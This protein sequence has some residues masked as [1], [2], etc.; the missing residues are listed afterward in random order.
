MYSVKAIS[1]KTAVFNQTVKHRIALL[2]QQGVMELLLNIARGPDS[3]NKMNDTVARLPACQSWEEDDADHAW[4]K[5][6][7]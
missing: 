6:T 5:C 1:V 4:R 7:G 3:S 2:Y